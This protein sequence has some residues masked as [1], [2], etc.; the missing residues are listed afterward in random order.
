M[1]Q[2]AQQQVRVHQARRRGR[3]AH[4]RVAIV[5]FGFCAAESGRKDR[6][7]PLDQSIFAAGTIGWS[8]TCIE[9]R[10]VARCACHAADSSRQQRIIE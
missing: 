5:A 2:R 7:L 10:A 6:H 8:E 4:C 1:V 9:A 3:R